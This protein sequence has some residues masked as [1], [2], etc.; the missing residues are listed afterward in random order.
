MLLLIF[1]WVFR[2]NIHNFVDLTVSS[3]PK[4][5]MLIH[6]SKLLAVKMKRLL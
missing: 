5:I 2:T 3:I 1:A 4:K 6:W